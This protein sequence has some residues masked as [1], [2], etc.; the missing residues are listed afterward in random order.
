MR[1]CP[2]G[3]IPLLV[4]MALISRSGAVATAQTTPVWGFADLHT[5][6]ASHMGFGADASGNNGIV[7]GKPGLDLATAPATLSADLP[8]CLVTNTVL[9]PNPLF[10][11]TPLFFLTALPTLPVPTT[12]LHG[13]GGLYSVG[14][15]ANRDQR[16][17]FT[18]AAGAP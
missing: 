9:F 11:G 5:H 10:A 3:S 7:W 15:P 6:P 1:A 4:A 17:R 14:E 8:P 18:D 13:S 2:G 16:A 12:S